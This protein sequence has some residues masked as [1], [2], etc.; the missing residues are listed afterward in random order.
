M[1]SADSATG[2][3][4]VIDGTVTSSVASAGMP[5]I[6][7]IHL[8]Y[9]LVTKNSNDLHDRG[10]RSTSGCLADDQADDI[11]LLPWIV[12]VHCR[13]VKSDII[14]LHDDGGSGWTSK[15]KCRL[16]SEQ[17]Q[18]VDIGSFT[19]GLSHVEALLNSDLPS[20]YIPYLHWTPTEPLPSKIEFCLVIA[21]CIRAGFMTPPRVETCLVGHG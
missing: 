8:S 6:P 5:A 2:S 7:E 10:T 18:V 16:S 19:Y 11:R 13:R 14:S 15:M 17:D 3:V 1:L 4:I 20:I 21:V 9:F 12:R